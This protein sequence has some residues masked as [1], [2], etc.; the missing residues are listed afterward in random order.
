[1]FCPKLGKKQNFS[2]PKTFSHRYSNDVP[3]KGSTEMYKWDEV[4]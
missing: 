1:M 3:F 4:S 2:S